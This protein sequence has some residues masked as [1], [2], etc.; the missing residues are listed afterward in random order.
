MS[1]CCWTSTCLGSSARSGDGVADILIDIKAKGSRLCPLAFETT[2][3]GIAGKGV[4]YLF[5]KATDQEA[6][7]SAP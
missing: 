2:V 3:D 7:E 5:S 4:L 6:V 1:D